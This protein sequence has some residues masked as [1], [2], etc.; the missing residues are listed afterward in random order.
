M[1]KIFHPPPPFFTTIFTVNLYKTY[2]Y[3]SYCFLKIHYSFLYNLVFRSSIYDI[4]IA[5]FFCLTGNQAVTQFTAPSVTPWRYRAET[6][7]TDP[8]NPG[9]RLVKYDNVTGQHLDYT[10]Y[11]INLTDSNRQENTTWVSLHANSYHLTL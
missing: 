1:A 9:V 4:L 3:N 8:H 5:Y 6:F 11:Y 7:T 2:V 10:Q